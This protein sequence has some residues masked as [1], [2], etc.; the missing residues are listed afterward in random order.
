MNAARV[1]SG[2]AFRFLTVS[3]LAASLTVFGAPATPASAKQQKKVTAEYD[4]SFNGFNIG[5][6]QLNSN[7]QD[8]EY[9]MKGTAQI[10]VL[11]GMLFEWRGD[12][13][14]S[15]R[16]AAKAPRPE[17]YSFGYKTAERRE[18][19][20]IE[21]TNNNVKQVAVNPPHREPA[22]RIPVTRNHMRNVVDPLSAIVLLTNVGSNKS[23]TEVCTRKLPIFDGKARYDLQLSYKK[24]QSV[25]TGH[26][27]SGP[28]YICKV[29]FQPI[30]GH[31]RGDSE[32]QYAAANEGIEI[33]M[34]PLAQADLYVPYY[35]YI[36]TAVGTATLTSSN[37]R[38]DTSVAAQG[39]SLR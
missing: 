35:I 32:S 20:S 21:F 19:I 10:S 34:I 38:V 9:R 3:C 1:V 36:P 8:D 17:S 27:Y 4:I 28:A 22:G 15:G 18:T 24:T 6:F 2:T 11:A 39:A 26:G 16:V 31:R 5:S 12:T 29:K 7:I 23:G 13:T 25:T 14:S 30:S 33:W 37:I